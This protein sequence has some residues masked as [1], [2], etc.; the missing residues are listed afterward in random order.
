[1]L[2]VCDHL[3][4]PVMLEISNCS[5]FSLTTLHSVVTLTVYIIYIFF[6]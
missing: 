1:M 2:K 6:I 5:S 4:G 3:P